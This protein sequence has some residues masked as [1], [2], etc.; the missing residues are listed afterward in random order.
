MYISRN[1]SNNYQHILNLYAIKPTILPWDFTK[2]IHDYNHIY[3]ITK[4]VRIN[5]Q[6]FSLNFSLHYSF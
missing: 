3:K 5:V 6:K 1:D 4:S 2:F